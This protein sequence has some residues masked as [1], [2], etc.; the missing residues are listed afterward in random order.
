MI[1]Q[2]KSL[3]Q[4][5]LFYNNYVILFSNIDV[6]IH[7]AEIGCIDK[8]CCRFYG[9]YESQITF[10]TIAHA[11]PECLGNKTSICLDERGECNK[12]F[13]K[14]IHHMNQICTYVNP[15]IKTS[16]WIRSDNFNTHKRYT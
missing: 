7:K 13:S 12:F 14:N 9:K 2:E 10:K 11:I 1:S 15:N 3:K 16:D 4:S 8:K 5:K 6:P